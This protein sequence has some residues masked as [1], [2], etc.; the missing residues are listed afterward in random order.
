MDFYKYHALGNDYIVIDPRK[1]YIELRKKNISL[2]CSRRTGIGADGIVLGPLLESGILKCRIF[3]PDG[4]EA[5]ISGNGIRI[6]AR[7]C[8]ES[9]YVFDKKFAIY[10]GTKKIMTELIDDEGTYV[11]VNLGS[12]SFN[13]TDIRAR[14]KPREIINEPFTVD[15]N[16]LAITCLSLGNP[17]CV[18]PLKK[19]SKELAEQI[20]P[21]IENHHLFPRRINVEFM[22]ALNRRTIVLEIW[23][24]GA[25][26]TH[27]SGSGASAAACA[28]YRLGL[29]G[30]SV[31]VRMPGG[32]LKV[33]IDRDLS[34]SITGP[35]ASIG[36]GNFSYE[37]WKEISR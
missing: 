30:N 19:I 26:Y 15:G 24:R 10:S 31:K 14:G 16:N 36:A 32:V 37:M 8:S 29:T 6:F 27:A 5:E 4:S 28:A 33:A 23:E 18:I 35:V 20:G 22:R 34:V 12:P 21:K 1:T 11:R 25:G 2:I 9:N 7:Y 17:H 13:S 3:N